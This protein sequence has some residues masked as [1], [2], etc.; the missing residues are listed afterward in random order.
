MRNFLFLLLAIAMITNAGMITPELQQ[1][2]NNSRGEFNIIVEMAEQFNVEAIKADNMIRSNDA[3]SREIVY[4][5]LKTKA[6]VSQMAV[7]HLLNV[8][9]VQRFWLVNAFAMT[10]D[11]ELINKLAAE[12]AVGKIYLDVEEMM[13]DPQQSSEETRLVWGVEY[14][15]TQ[16]ARDKGITG[17]GIVVAV[18]D[19]GVDL[20]HP[21]FAPGQVLVD[22]SKSFIDNEPT[23]DDGNGHGTHC[24]GTIG[25]KGY[26]VAPDCKILPVK[27][28]SAGGSGSWTAVMNGVQYAAEQKVDIMSMSLGG[29]ASTSGN[30]VET[31]VKN[32][33]ASGVVCVIAAGNSGP[34][35]KTIG[36]PGVVLEAI[37]VGAINSSGTI[38]SFSSRG[39]TVYNTEKPDIVAPGVNVPSLWKNG[40]TN[41]ISGTSMA[42]PHVAGL[43]ALILQAKPGLTPAKV[44]ALIM[45]TAFGK[46]EANV[47]GKGCVDAEATTK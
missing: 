6:E 19:T 10:A 23:A 15:K 38:A 27:V 41:T 47:Y 46:A 35:A 1:A 29:R 20:D 13:I 2:M 9:N 12:E 37:T 26:G 14:I 42:T 32:A 22:Q 18:V 43:C 5:I 11:A 8:R 17:K 25:S 30:V 33:I 39:V 28:L 45:D 7:N 31:A 4:D 40:G 16:A 36:T 34:S 24:A 44:K 3:A 21:G